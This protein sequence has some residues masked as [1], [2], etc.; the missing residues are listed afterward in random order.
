[1]AASSGEIAREFFER[2]WNRRDVTAF[3]EMS[4]PTSMAYQPD[5]TAMTAQQFR[6][7]QYPEF[8]KAFP[9]LHIDV[10]DVLES[11]HQAV[12][13]WLATGTHSG[14]GFGSRAT[15]QKVAFR[16]MTW[17]TFHNGKVGSGWNCWDLGGLIQRINQAAPA[18]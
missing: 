5:G 14:D 15:G 17:F 2:F 13:R 18:A 4:D 12:V 11:D 3:D 8:L 6:D 16:G 7:V 10:E 9:D 1:M